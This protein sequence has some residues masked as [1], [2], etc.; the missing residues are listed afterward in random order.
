MNK[1]FLPFLQRSTD[2]YTFDKSLPY[3]KKKTQTLLSN[4]Q[5]IRIGTHALIKSKKK[6]KCF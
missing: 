2:Y 6:K 4:R 3:Q 5:K 1:Y